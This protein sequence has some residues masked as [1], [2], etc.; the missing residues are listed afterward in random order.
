MCKAL[1][2]HL[3]YH[4]RE[5]TREYVNIGVGYRYSQKY[6]IDGTTNEVSVERTPIDMHMIRYDD[7]LRKLYKTMKKK[8]VN[9]NANQMTHF[10]YEESDK[11]ENE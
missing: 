3:K 9:P 7:Q 4:P 10:Q 6:V 11:K 8:W 1:R 5:P 2:K